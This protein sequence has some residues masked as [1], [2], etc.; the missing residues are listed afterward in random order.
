MDR[1]KATALTT[2]Y[3]SHQGTYNLTYQVPL[4]SKHPEARASK[5]TKASVAAVKIDP[6]EALLLYP[7][8]NFTTSLLLISQSLE[9]N[10]HPVPNPVPETLNP[11]HVFRVYGF[12]FRV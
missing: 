6:A 4:S 5:G 2:T 7:T 10:P 3:S 1:N 8:H 12:G 9:W 11:K